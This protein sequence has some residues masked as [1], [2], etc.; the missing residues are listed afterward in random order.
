MFVVSCGTG[1][2]SVYTVTCLQGPGSCMPYNVYMYV[3]VHTVHVHI[4]RYKATAL[5]SLDS[6]LPSTG[7]GNFWVFAPLN[8]AAFITPSIALFFVRSD[9]DPDKWF[10]RAVFNFILGS[11]KGLD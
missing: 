2:G 8:F 6:D 11:F 4:I 3:Y 9:I 5:S 10:I 7:Y 1:Y